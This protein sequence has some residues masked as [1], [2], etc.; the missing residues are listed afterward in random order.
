M[1]KP[2]FLLSLLCVLCLASAVATA[3]DVVTVPLTAFNAGELSPT[4]EGRVDYS[5]YAQGLRQCENLLPLTQ[6]PVIRRPG[7]QYVAST[8]NN[9][10]V[11]LI[12]FEYSVDDTY[13]LEFGDLYMRVYRNQAQ[14]LDV[15]DD[16]YEIVTPFDANEIADLQF[17]QTSNS[18]YLVDGNDP[19]QVLTRTG[20]TSWTIEDVEFTTGPFQPRLTGNTITLQADWADDPNVSIQFTDPNALD[21]GCI[22]R[23][24]GDTWLAQTFTTTDAVSIQGVNL[25]LYREKAD[26]YYPLYV[27]IRATDA[28]E[29]DGSDLVVGKTIASSLTR[30][31][32]GEWRVIEFDDSYILSAATKYA[33]VIR[34]TTP[35]RAMTRFLHGGYVYWRGDYDGGYAGG[36]G[37][38]SNDA[39]E[40]WND[41]DTGQVDLAF[42]LIGTFEGP[43]FSGLPVTLTADDDLFHSGHEDSIWKLYHQRSENNVTGEFDANEVGKIIPITG[44]YTA[45]THGTWTGTVSLKRSYDGGAT[46]ETVNTVASADD[47]NM[48]YSGTETAPNVFYRM[49]MV[50]YTSGT[51]TYQIG[52]TDYY[53]YGIIKITDVNDPCTAAGIILDNPVST[54]PTTMWQEGYWSY[55]RGWPKAIAFHEQRLWFGGSTDYPQTIWATQTAESE[56][57]YEDMTVVP[58]D[59]DSALIYMLPGK[60]PIAWLFSHSYLM[61]GSAGGVGR[62]GSLDEGMT[63]TNIEYRLQTQS[64]A[65]PIQPVGIGDVLLYVERGGRKVRQYLYQ[66]DVD[67]FIAPDV[68]ILAEHVTS[69]GLVGMALQRS[70]QPVLWAPRAD[71]EAVTMT[72]L[73]EEEVTAWARQ[74]TDGQI[75]SIATLPG[76]EEDEVWWS[77]ARTIDSNTVRY[78]EILKPQDWGTDQNDCWFVDSGLSFE[79]GDAVA[80]ADVNQS[81]PGLVTVSEWPTDANGESL[82]NGDQIRF[83]NLSGM[84]ELNEQV[85][86]IADANEGALT[87]TLDYWKQP[88]AHWKFNDAADTNAVADSSGN[89]HDGT[90]SQDTNDMTVTG[91]IN[92]ALEFNGTDDYVNISDHA[93]LRLTTGGTIMAWIKPDSLGETAGRIVDKSTTTSGTNGFLFCLSST[94]RLQFRVS[95]H[96]ATLSGNG[97]FALATWSH[98]AVS[99]DGTT[100]KFYGDGEMISEQ[101]YAYLPPNVAGDLRIG[102]RAGATDRS[103]D[104]VIDDVRIYST[105]LAEGEIRKLYNDASDIDDGNTVDLTA[106][107]TGGTVQEVENTFGDL[108]H[109]EGES[110][111][112]WG[113]AAA[114]DAMTV[115]DANIVLDDFYNAVIVGLP[116]TSTMETMP[117][118]I[119]TS[120]GPMLR[121]QKRVSTIGIDFYQSIGATAGASEATL[122]DVVRNSTST[123][124]YTE[125]KEISDVDV[126][127]LRKPTIWI[128]QEDPAPMCVRQIEAVVRVGR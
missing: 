19:P 47:D 105:V 107:T 32:E 67:Q 91:H 73:R 31:P 106:Y 59:D 81:S 25:K 122:Q 128:R 101:A 99:F 46:W 34:S 42:S 102:Q 68:S 30:N 120:S 4:M 1:V 118:V 43:H 35:V 29:P 127:W 53:D 33:I 16:P 124:L 75:E 3:Q 83:A 54:E 21:S 90:A 125:W 12:P 2:S 50:S 79:G 87:F 37:W 58:L 61:V 49:E 98:V 28:N 74:I 26:A 109:L 82:A 24:R 41:L 115:V 51:A 27:S 121:N 36:E 11:R 110:L 45:T 95:G 96:V 84:T 76:S 62:L 57:D 44:S 92:G 18:M 60:N 13:M 119:S 55:Y 103:F 94:T 66:Y 116:Y 88:L 17:V 77:V 8:K 48:T 93:D 38:I 113:D 126:G 112:V 15:N 123:D 104:G 20:H 10:A 85:Y 80:I 63:P 9:G 52:A 56:G 39:G 72:Y 64:G 97:A 5:K 114:Q 23:V 69:G 14:V 40:N 86:T 89:D 6:G 65:S 7:S 22:V 117:L 78:I 108:S 100:V 70:P 111:A 71:G